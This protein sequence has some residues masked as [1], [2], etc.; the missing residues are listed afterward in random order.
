MLYFINN[1]LLELIKT[2]DYNTL[3]VSNYDVIN[4][5]YSKKSFNNNNN[6]KKITYV[7]IKQRAYVTKLVL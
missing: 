2:I 3:F 5:M 4:I 7:K 1:N 6:N